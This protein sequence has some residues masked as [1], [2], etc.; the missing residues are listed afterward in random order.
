MKEY[1]G[2]NCKIVINKEGKKYFY[3]ANITDLTEQHITFIDKFGD[4]YTYEI[5][6]IKRIKT[7]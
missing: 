1:I 2:K 3:I 5:E 6:D 4:I 7:I